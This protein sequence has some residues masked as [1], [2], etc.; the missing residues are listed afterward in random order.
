VE[1]EWHIFR[2]DCE[3]IVMFVIVLEHV[4]DELDMLEDIPDTKKAIEQ[5]M[6]VAKS[7]VLRDLQQRSP[8]MF[9]LY[10]HL[11]A[12]KRLLLAKKEIMHHF[13]TE[14]IISHDDCERITDH[15][16]EKRL[17][18]V[19]E[20]V[21]SMQV[22]DRC[23]QCVGKELGYQALTVPGGRVAF[24]K[25]ADE[26][27]ALAKL[28]HA[29]S[30]ERFAR[31]N[32]LLE[33]AKWKA[34]RPELKLRIPLK[35]KAKA[36]KKLAV[37]TGA[38]AQEQ[39]RKAEEQVQRA[40]AAG[41]KHV[42]KAAHQARD[43]ALEDTQELRAHM[44]AAA[45]AATSVVTK[46]HDGGRQAPRPDLHAVPDAPGGAKSDTGTLSPKLEAPPPRLAALPELDEDVC[47][48]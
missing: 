42:L 12:A 45:G 33:R 40:G 44:K 6:T 34:A 5:L 46:L 20:Y 14:G 1:I 16:L 15:I 47:R 25:A 37:A 32:R 36:L 39:A 26:K 9:C 48:V 17:H 29:T 10:E 11:L 7:E 22:L 3:I 18:A 2:R 35:E 41:K 19:A 27:D 43:V 13:M 8:I 21:P 38:K 31:Q 28:E 24:V 4:L 23:G 30:M